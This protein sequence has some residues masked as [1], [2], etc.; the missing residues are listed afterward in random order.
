MPVKSQTIV[1][2]KMRITPFY[3][4]G[5]MQSI[6]KKNCLLVA[7]KFST[8]LLP[9]LKIWSDISQTISLAKCIKK[10]GIFSPIATFAERKKKLVQVHS[11]NSTDKLFIGINLQPLKNI[12]RPSLYASQNKLILKDFFT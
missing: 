10:H 1:R 7:N 11:R 8:I 4:T 6:F 5:Y 9:E 2:P 12:G 3:F